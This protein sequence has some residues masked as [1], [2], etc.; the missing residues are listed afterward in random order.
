M[1]PL[2]ATKLLNGDGLSAILDLKL[3][4]LLPIESSGVPMLMQ[5]AHLNK[6][7]YPPG[8]VS[9]GAWIGGRLGEGLEAGAAKGVG[10]TG[11]WE[12]TWERQQGQS[13]SVIWVMSGLEACWS[14]A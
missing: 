4:A 9:S 14:C 10:V 5:F 1:Q 6:I 11:A 7:F 3:P 12:N 13:K 8:T 2:P